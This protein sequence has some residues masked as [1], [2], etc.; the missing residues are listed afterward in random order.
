MLFRSGRYVSQ[1]P[2]GLM[3]GENLYAYVPNPAGWMDP[4]GWCSTTLG[5]N[6]G[7][8]SGDGMANHHLIPKQLM[9]SPRFAAM[10]DRLKQMGFDPDGAGNGTFLPGSQDLAQKIG[11]PGHWSNHGQYTAEIESR[12]TALNRLFQSNQISDTSLAIGI[13][14][15]QNWAAQGLENGRFVVDQITGRLL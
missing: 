15:I 13:K 3:G 8:R 6:M 2:I 11:M 9:N 10:F 5:K 1:D 4:W 7:A 14:N 12:L